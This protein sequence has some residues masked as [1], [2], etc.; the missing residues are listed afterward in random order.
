MKTVILSGGAGTRITA[1]SN[2]RPKTLIEIGGRP[3]L[4]HIMKQFSAHGH[5]QFLVALGDKGNMVKRYLLEYSTLEQDMHIDMRNGSVSYAEAE[6]PQWQ[7]DLVDTGISTKTGGRLRRLVH[8]LNDTFLLTWGDT[9]S[10]IDLPALVDYHHSHNKLV[11]LTIVRPV[12][13][14]G[15]IVFEGDA[16]AEFNE[17]PQT[18][19]GWINSGV[20][21]VEPEAINYIDSEQEMW[22]HAPLQRLAAAGELMSFE[23][24]GFWHCCDT[25]RDRQTLESLWESGK[26]PWAIWDNPNLATAAHASN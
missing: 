5:D 25:R 19:E 21:V 24:D 26:R 15:H 8:K 23:H 4:W 9:F 11:T 14:F 13:R 12:A 10:N 3:L 17:K 1:D 6:R 22:S 7:I 18:A 16:V 20:C 2:I